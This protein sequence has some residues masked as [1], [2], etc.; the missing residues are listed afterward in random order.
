VPPAHDLL[1]QVTF[2]SSEANLLTSKQLGR[3]YAHVI[4]LA[5]DVFFKGDHCPS[6][7]I[8]RCIRLF[9]TLL[10][11]PVLQNI[12]SWVVQGLLESRVFETSLINSYPNCHHFYFNLSHLVSTAMWFF[13]HWLCDSQFCST[14]QKSMTQGYKDKIKSRMAIYFTSFTKVALCS[15]NLVT[16]WRSTCFLQEVYLHEY[17]LFLT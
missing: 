7:Y 10:E 12:A 14:I 15:T 1:L 3:P 2:P 9:I 5:S 13:P 11:Y 8:D 6:L 17:V 4:P 16:M